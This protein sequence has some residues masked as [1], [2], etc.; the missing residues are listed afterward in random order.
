MKVLKT[1]LDMYINADEETI[2]SEKKIEYYKTIL[3]LIEDTLKS[4]EQRGWDIKNAQQQQ[5]HLAGGF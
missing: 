1:D 2:E 5:I 4:I 3:G